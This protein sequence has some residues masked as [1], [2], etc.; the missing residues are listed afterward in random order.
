MLKAKLR[1]CYFSIKSYKI[2]NAIKKYFLVEKIKQFFKSYF[3]IFFMY[4]ELFLVIISWC[5]LIIY[6]H[7]ETMHAFFL[8]IILSNTGVDML[9]NFF[10]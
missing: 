4:V 3:N 6:L 1:T 9:C 7:L 10:L 2:L 5:M 8:L